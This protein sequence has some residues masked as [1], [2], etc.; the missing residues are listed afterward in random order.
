VHD[1]VKEGT[2]VGSLHGAG[3]GRRDSVRGGGGA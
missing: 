3:G 2:T 1:R